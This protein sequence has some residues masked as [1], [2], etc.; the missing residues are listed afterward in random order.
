MLTFIEI[1]KEESKFKKF[2]KKLFKKDEEKE[3]VEED[4]WGWDIQLSCSTSYKEDSKITTLKLDE[5][6]NQI[7]Q[8]IRTSE[9][10]IFISYK[11]FKEYLLDENFIDVGAT[12]HSKEKRLKNILEFLEAHTRSY[13]NLFNDGHNYYI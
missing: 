9:Y 7:V 4:F 11:K 13:F 3:V 1:W 8:E 2:F 12:Y 6:E 5:E 10:K